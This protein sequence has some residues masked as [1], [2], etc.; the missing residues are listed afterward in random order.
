M[1]S[2]LKALIDE[3]KLPKAHLDTKRLMRIFLGYKRDPKDARAKLKAWIE[4]LRRLS[5]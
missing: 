2:S 3:Q 4:E 1:W 5:P